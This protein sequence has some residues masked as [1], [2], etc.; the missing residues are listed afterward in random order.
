MKSREEIVANNKLEYIQQEVL[1]LYWAKTAL[2]PPLGS[3]I[4]ITEIFALVLLYIVYSTI[5]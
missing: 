2:A 1:C 4:S 5:K 3:P